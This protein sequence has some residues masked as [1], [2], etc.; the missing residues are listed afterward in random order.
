MAKSKIKEVER[1]R[2]VS[3]MLITG[4]ELLKNRYM[5]LSLL[6]D[7]SIFVCSLSLCILAFV[8]PDKLSIYIGAKAKVVVGLFSFFTLVMTCLTGRL[9][10]RVKAEKHA[11]SA[12]KYF[13]F[14]KECN[15]SSDKVKIGD[16]GT[17]AKLNEMYKAVSSST[18]KISDKYFL[19][20]KKKHNL[21]VLISKHLDTNPSISLIIF[22]IK[23]WLRDNLFQNRLS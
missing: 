19:K 21:K 3:D 15:D 4:H 14:K 2:R 9:D 13:D 8:E 10:W 11:S 12:Q 20:I 18:E 16:A 23:L 7:V 5:F 17:I 6:T 22:R 1:M